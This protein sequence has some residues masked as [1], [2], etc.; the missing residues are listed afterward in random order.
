MA[1]IRNM[2]IS[3]QKR[4]NLLAKLGGVKIE[5]QRG[6]IGKDVSFDT[7]RPDLVIIEDGAYITEGC[8][9]YTHHLDTRIF[10]T[11]KGDWW[12][13]GGVRICRNAFIGSHSI[14]CNSVTIGEGAVVG[15][16]SVVTKD[17]PSYEIWGGNPAKFIKRRLIE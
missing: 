14:I 12:R 10:H 9:I 17:I 6:F 5:G 8:V 7:I 16:G 13:Y 4:Y 2:P 15:A 3:G 1:I 11:G